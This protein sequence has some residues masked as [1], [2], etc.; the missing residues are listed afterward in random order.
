MTKHNEIISYIKQLE[1][2]T[3]ISVRGI[4]ISLG[5]SEGTAYRAIK[6]AENQG[7]VNTIP[8]VGTVRVEDNEEGDIEKFTYTEI[9]DI[10]GG[11][12]TAGKDGLYKRVNKLFIGAMTPDIIEK[13]I[14][15]GDLLIIGNREDA[16][17]IGL[18]KECGLLITGGFDCADEI[19][20][21][22]DELKIP[23]ILTDYDTFTAATLINRA[24]YFKMRKKEILLVRD[25]MVE[26]PRCL[27]PEDKV[28][29]W[30]NT[31][32][33]TGH[34]RFPVVNEK[35]ELLGVVTS[36]DVA[37]SSPDETIGNVMTKNPIATTPQ[38]TVAYAAHT[39]VWQGIELMPVVEGKKLLGIISR[40][41][42]IKAFQDMYNQ[43][44][45]EQ[46][47][48]D[49]LLKNFEATFEQNRAIFI[50]TVPSL[51]LSH[52]GMAS[53]PS[54]SLLMAAAGLSAVIGN[55]R[56]EAEVENFNIFYVRPIQIDIKIFI[57]AK[58]I[59]MSRNFSKVEITVSSEDEIL[60]RGILSVRMFKS[61]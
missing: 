44:Q 28:D 17:R 36:R 21:W 22:A 29:T 35:N 33:E 50:G 38:M 49:L 61:R 34:T 14:S 8:R 55:K 4:S 46:T 5:V 19:K 25:V 59:D 12:C 48:E 43:P 53:F 39:M 40:E 30:R 18:S 6:E 3:R 51:M 57:E 10:V 45:V 42:V 47:I 41:D 52:G 32:L 9:V 60:A 37:D 54:L 56:Y 7:Y 27:R 20:A 2:G 16:Q 13:Y 31:V 1:P 11:T 58:V 15:P 24:I 23:V 26:S